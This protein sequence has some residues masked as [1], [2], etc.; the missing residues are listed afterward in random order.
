MSLFLYGL[1]IKLTCTCIGWPFECHRSPSSVKFDPQTYLH[2][3]GLTLCV[4]QKL[5]FT[6]IW[7]SNVLTFLSFLD[8]PYPL[9][10]LTD[11]TTIASLIVELLYQCCY[12]CESIYIIAF[13]INFDVGRSTNVWSRLEWSS[14]C[15]RQWWR[16]Y[17]SARHICALCDADQVNC[18][19]QSH[20]L[21]P[22]KIMA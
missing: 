20:H 21:V 2:L 7:P 14:S 5:T 17:R 4:L 16:C 11:V 15:W 13:L 3:Y 19:I 22:V 10:D 18:S 9:E 1:A 12:N 8:Y 6:C